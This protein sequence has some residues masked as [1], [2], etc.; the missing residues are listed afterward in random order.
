MKTGDLLKLIGA[1]YK[2]ADLKELND[3][4]KDKPEALQIALNGSNLSDVKD[5]LSLISDEDGVVPESEMPKPSESETTPD[6]KSMYEELKKKSEAQEE[7]IKEIQTNNQRQD[8]SG[9]RQ[10]D[11]DILKDIVASFM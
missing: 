9:D 8:Q 7:K 2:P 6:Y 3:L 10:S 1:G 5:Y 4:S 11:E